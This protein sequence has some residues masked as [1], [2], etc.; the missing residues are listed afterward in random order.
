MTR[1]KVS[2]KG[3]ISYT[4]RI[5]YSIFV[6]YGI[7]YM[8]VGEHTTRQTASLGDLISLFPSL[9]V[10][11]SSPL[12]SYSLYSVVYTTMRSFMLLFALVALFTVG[13]QCGSSSPTTLPT[14]LDYGMST[15]E[16]REEREQR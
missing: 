4:I 8:V 11:F 7:D 15:K 10:F 2:G 6:P 14:Q 13:V 5:I 16:V 1:F 12:S 9:L 3:L